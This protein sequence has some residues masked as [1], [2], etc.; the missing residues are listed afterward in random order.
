MALIMLVALVACVCAHGQG[1]KH[2]KN[3]AETDPFAATPPIAATEVAA[4]VDK[5]YNHIHTLQLDFVEEYNGLGVERAEQGTL[6]LKKPGQMRW[7]YTRPKGKIFVVDKH[8]AY[9]YTPGD[10]Q[11]QHFPV[12]N[13]DDLRSPLRFLLGHTDLAREMSNLAV[14]ADGSEYHLR[15]VPVGMEKRVTSL[16]LTTTLDGTILA[17]RILETG[18][19]MTRF[20][21]YGEKDNVQA[22]KQDFVF[23]PPSGVKVVDGPP[24]M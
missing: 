9:A 5:H 20:Q 23:V 10:A 17:M 19:A 24:P 21:F 15:G 4:R 3:A 12:A 14:T 2:G 1:R 16:E 6:L 8:D 7:S 13:L 11:A 22:T 18:G